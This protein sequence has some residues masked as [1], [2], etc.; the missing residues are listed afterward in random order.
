MGTGLVKSH[1]I[2][3]AYPLF[4]KSPLNFMRRG[5]F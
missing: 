2:L 1:I 3:L 5:V 4:Y